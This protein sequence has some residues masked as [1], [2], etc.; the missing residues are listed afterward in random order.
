MKNKWKQ[1]TKKVTD[2]VK[3][4]YMKS[5]FKFHYSIFLQQRGIMRVARLKT[6]FWNGFFL[7]DQDRLNL[8]SGCIKNK[9][10]LDESQKSQNK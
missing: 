6:C 9:S 7:K 2:E 10:S 5:F 8:N 1:I 3:I 4:S